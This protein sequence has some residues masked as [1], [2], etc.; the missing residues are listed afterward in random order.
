MNNS[1]IAEDNEVE[2]PK[3]FDRT[4]WLRQREGELIKIIEAL[5]G[6]KE[7]DYWK[8]LSTYIF[9]GLVESL[10]KRINT[11]AQ[12]NDPDKQELARLTG[13]MVWAKKFSDLSKLKDIYR[14]ELTNVRK[15]LHGN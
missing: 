6:V 12:K 5:D 13:Q 15:Q 4:P 11:E 7:S 8:T 1:K 10:D 14:V 3:E 9:D 2:P